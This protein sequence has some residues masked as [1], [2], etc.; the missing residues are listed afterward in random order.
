MENCNVCKN[1]GCTQHER[2]E[3]TRA[4]VRAVVKLTIAPVISS[5]VNCKY[6]ELD[7]SKLAKCCPNTCKV[8]DSNE[9]A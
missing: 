6:F 7:E 9:K 2:M 3:N 8:G 1:S 4:A 5:E